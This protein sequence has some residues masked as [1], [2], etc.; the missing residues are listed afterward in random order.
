MQSSRWD[1][2]W[3]T[4]HSVT[5][6]SPRPIQPPGM[7]RNHVGRRPSFARTAGAVA[8][9]APNEI[10]VRAARPR[11]NGIVK[12]CGVEKSPK[13]EKAEAFASF[14]RSEGRSPE[15]RETDAARVAAR[16]QCVAGQAM[17]RMFAFAHS[18]YGTGGIPPGLNDVILILL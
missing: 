7:E 13:I 1:V 16:T 5:S 6:S 8:S 4:V 10:G 14:F 3:S 18:L 9:P 11:R 17:V 12:I 15:R 2:M